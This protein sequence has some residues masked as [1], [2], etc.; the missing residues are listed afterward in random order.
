MP[1]TINQNVTEPQGKTRQGPAPGV[2]AAVP[3]NHPQPGTN[4][5]N[6]PREP[7]IVGACPQLDHHLNA[8]PHGLQIRDLRQAEGGGR[9]LPLDARQDVSRCA[10][11]SGDTASASV[12]VK[13]VY[14]HI[15]ECNGK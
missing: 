11:R 12:C 5:A 3:A 8:E 6:G 13:T 9:C 14:T 10:E 4:G 7:L 1:S 15:Y 2:R